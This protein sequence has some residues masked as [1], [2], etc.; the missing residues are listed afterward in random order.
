MK[1]LKYFGLILILLFPLKVNGLISFD[2]S[3]V[4]KPG[5]DIVCSIKSD[6]NI[7][8][9]EGTLGVDSKGVYFGSTPGT[10]FTS[11]S[12]QTDLKFRS[13]EGSKSVATTYIHVPSSIKANTSFKMSLSNIKYILGGSE[14]T[15]G[16]INTETSIVVATTKPTTTTTASANS[17]KTFTVI[18][19]SNNSENSKKTLSCTTSGSNCNIDLTSVTIPTK[20]GYAFAG[21]GN[22]ILCTTGNLNSYKADS[23]TT[24]YACWKEA[25][26]PNEENL[27]L[28]TL[29]IEGQDI[30]FS[31]FK[32][33]YDLTVLYEVENLVITATATSD[34][35]T[36][37]IPEDTTLEVGENE[38][39]IN[40]TNDQGESS[41]YTI[42]VIRL[43]EGEEIRTL[44]SDAS[45]SS[46][47][48][49]PYTVDFSPTTFNYTIE[50]DSKTT[51]LS[52]TAVPSS[53]YASYE[54]IGNTN[55]EEGSIIKIEVMAEDGTIIVY[56]FH[57][58]VKQNILEEYKLYILIAGAL[59]LVLIIIV[60]IISSNNKKK[61]KKAKKSLAPAKKEPT[62]TMKTVPKNVAPSKPTP[63]AAPEVEVLDI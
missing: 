7:T 45:L 56:N 51:E 4:A 48:L 33:T 26:T 30:G 23:D 2:C 59:M 39:I 42:K 13:D 20:I 24:L 16:K 21:W 28:Q 47:S 3:G 12:S 57:I 31:K 43:N 22:S 58:S 50:I 41:I 32:F 38:I 54:V 61:K 36:V 5:S 17:P 46:V 15:Q 9:F 34:D 27:Y 55:L 29:N 11:E 1:Y 44:S 53:E 8:Y 62:K 25:E 19:D 37:E 35:A 63:P 49:E 52:V 40:L 14:N 60:I 18:L 10:G 6:T